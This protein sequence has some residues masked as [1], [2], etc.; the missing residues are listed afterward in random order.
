VFSL[1]FTLSN[2]DVFLLVSTVRE[3]TAR[4]TATVAASIW[5]PATPITSCLAS[6]S[7]LDQQKV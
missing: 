2:T 3:A 5:K 6:L 4:I 7:P 1:A